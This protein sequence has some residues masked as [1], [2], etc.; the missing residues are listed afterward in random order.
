MAQQGE[1][2]AHILGLQAFTTGKVWYE[3]IHRWI[4][5]I[6]LLHHFFVAALQGG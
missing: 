6:S 1:I 2:L 5:L 4:Q 3:I